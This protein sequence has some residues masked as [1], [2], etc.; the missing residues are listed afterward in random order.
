MEEMFYMDKLLEN[1]SFIDINELNYLN[2][3]IPILS[4]EEEKQ[5]FIKKMNGDEQARTKLILHNYRLILSITNKYSKSDIFEDLNQAGYIGLITAIDNFDV[6]R[7]LKFSTYAYKWIIKYVLMFIQQNS[8]ISISQNDN[9]NIRLIN[10]AIKQLKSEK[11]GITVEN[12]SELTDLTDKKIIQILESRK[13]TV[14]LNDKVMEDAEIVFSDILCSLDNVEEQVEEKNK[15]NDLKKLF[16]LSNLNDEEISVLLLKYGFF[17]VPKQNS[18]IAQ[19]LN[20]KK[21]RIN[22]LESS[23]LRKIRTSPYFKDIIDFLNNEP[24]GKYYV[25]SERNNK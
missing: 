15:I 6:S 25:K 18:V 23:G 17:G 16:Y 10:T 22:T 7:D 5:L 12:I 1:K 19:L 3:K 9:N 11:R 4:K 8:T 20:I 24:G 2:R 13:K 21:T 14:S